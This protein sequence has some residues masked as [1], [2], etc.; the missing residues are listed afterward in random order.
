MALSIPIAVG[1]SVDPALARS[2]APTL[3]LLSGRDDLPDDAMVLVGAPSAADLP[4]ALAVR[5]LVVIPANAAAD[6]P[7]FRV[8][9]G[10]ASEVLD[11]E[12]APTAGAAADG[13]EAADPTDPRA[14]EVLALLSG[15]DPQRTPS[16]IPVRLVSGGAVG[17]LQAREAWAAGA[18]V[19]A[20]PGPGAADLRRTR[21]ALVAGSAVEAAEALLLLERTPRLAQALATR[22]RDLV[23]QLP[24]A[25]AAAEL[26]AAALL[27][28]AAR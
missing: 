5:I 11:L 28:A 8:V 13:L 10:R 26:I 7:Y 6:D 12:P 1:P 4:R 24:D 20:L 3:A 9:R 18:A 23:A 15:I 27:R 21:A 22:G 2:F 14:A 16:P 25:A 17:M 19:V